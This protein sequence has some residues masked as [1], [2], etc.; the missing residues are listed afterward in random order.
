M[1]NMCAPLKSAPLKSSRGMMRRRSSVREVFSSKASG[2]VQDQ[3]L[4][5]LKD[6][7]ATG[8]S[9]KGLNSILMKFP[10]VEEGMLSVR[11]VFFDREQPATNAIK[12]ADFQEACA[13]VGL[14]CPDDMLHS[15]LEQNCTVDETDLLTLKEFIAT[16]AVVYLLLGK[17]TPAE[18]NKTEFMHA[19]DTVV[20]AFNY[21]D[22][23]GCGL[24]H[25]E[26][27]LS[28]FNQR[29][30]A[31]HAPSHSPKHQVPRISQARF[32]EMDWDEDEQISFTEFLFAFESWVGVD[33]ELMEDFRSRNSTKKKLDKHT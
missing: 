11:C 28:V 12:T 16:L 1:G 23:Q 30:S 32:E 6:A 5:A 15:I 31:A 27:V 14:E 7:R 9:M 8:T 26:N 17:E 22:E 29:S 2:F 25:K 33:E 13:A 4:R 3:V 10:K 24:V 18:E 19:I 21:F 20:D